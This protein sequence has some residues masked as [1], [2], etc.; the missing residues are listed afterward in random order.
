MAKDTSFAAK[1]AK[2]ASDRDTTNCPKCGEAYAN[3]KLISSVRSETK[4]SW[5]FL[6]NFVLVCSCNQKE[7]YI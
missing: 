3:V 1:T 4:N 5:K 6:Q 7:I 2:A